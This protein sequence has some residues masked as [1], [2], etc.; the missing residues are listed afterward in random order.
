[1]SSGDSMVGPGAQETD[2]M[3]AIGRLITAALC[4]G[5]ILGVVRFGGVGL[6]LVATDAAKR[7]VAQRVVALVV[8]S[9]LA[10]PLGASRRARA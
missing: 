6:L 2:V 4:L 8:L 9:G 10:G 7:V 5:V 3:N 1:M